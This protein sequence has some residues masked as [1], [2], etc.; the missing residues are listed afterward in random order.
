LRFMVG[1]KTLI[2]EICKIRPK[3]RRCQ[4]QWESL[5]YEDPH[6]QN[7]YVRFSG[8]QKKML[9]FYWCTLYLFYHLSFLP[10][11]KYQISHWELCRAMKSIKNPFVMLR[12][13]LV[14]VNPHS[15][16]C[17][18]VLKKPVLNTLHI[19][20]WSGKEETD[21]HF[22]SSMIAETYSMHNM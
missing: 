11:P 22:C 14:L 3:K 17:R 5:G 10:P 2:L 16:Q 18:L 7:K 13:E 8:C 4:Q 15:Y 20:V 9:S 1:T 19:S 12:K 6:N 21:C